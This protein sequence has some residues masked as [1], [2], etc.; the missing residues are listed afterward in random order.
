MSK[1]R[2]TKTLWVTLLCTGMIVGL[3]ALIVNDLVPGTAP[4]PPPDPSTLAEV[5]RRV[6]PKDNPI[7]AARCQ[8]AVDQA[9]SAKTERTQGRKK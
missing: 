1:K 6:D 2:N 3:V 5:C 9:G 4:P 7:L 8:R